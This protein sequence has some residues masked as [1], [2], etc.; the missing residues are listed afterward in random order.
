MRKRRPVIKA[1]CEWRKAAI[2]CHPGRRVG[3]IFPIGF[4]VFPKG[5]KG[6]P[7]KLLA[8]FKSFAGTHSHLNR[9]EQLHP[10]GNRRR[11][12]RQDGANGLVSVPKR[13]GPSGQ[14]IKILV[15][16]GLAKSASGRFKEVANLCRMSGEPFGSSREVGPHRDAACDHP[17]L[18]AKPPQCPHPV[19]QR[20]QRS[21]V[22][23]LSA[24]VRSESRPAEGILTHDVFDRRLASRQRVEERKDRRQRRGRIFQH[25]DDETVRLPPLSRHVSEWA[26]ALRGDDLA[27]GAKVHRPG[28]FRKLVSDLPARDGEPFQSVDKIARLFDSAIPDRRRK[29]LGGCVRRGSD[30]RA[31]RRKPLDGGKAG[32]LLCATEPFL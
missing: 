1:G 2:R 29:C 18:G 26:C 12:V 32:Q 13:T 25:G 11:D 15:E 3:Q 7:T 9:P 4:V 27:S 28:R 5:A 24:P 8:L 23:A 10:G 21:R 19:H 6:R 16:I 14:C 31:E 30:S 22:G 20:T 17:G